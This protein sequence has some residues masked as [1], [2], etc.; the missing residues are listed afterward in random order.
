[1]RELRLLNAA[2]TLLMA[3]AMA[4]EMLDVLEGM[5]HTPT[6][7]ESEVSVLNAKIANDM[8]SRVGLTSGQR[9]AALEAGANMAKVAMANR[10]SGHLQ[11]VPPWN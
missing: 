8:A 4:E 1:M 2:V 7:I 5:G 6:G 9:L 11:I 3:S 10:G